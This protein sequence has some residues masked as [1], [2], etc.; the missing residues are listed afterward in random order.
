MSDQNPIS[1]E[2]AVRS[3]D[4]TPLADLKT[5]PAL[6]KALNDISTEAHDVAN[7]AEFLDAV[8]DMALTAPYADSC[9]CSTKDDPPAW[10]HKVDR[11]RD[12]LRC[13]YRC[14]RCSREWTCG[15]SVDLPRWL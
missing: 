2:T 5:Y 11:D 13:G 3:F 7:L 15:Y 6:R 8:R 4:H 12:W 1:Y 9:D 14:D 10:P